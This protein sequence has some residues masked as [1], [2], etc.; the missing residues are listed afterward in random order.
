MTLTSGR[1]YEISQPK[2]KKIRNF[3]NFDSEFYHHTACDVTPSEGYPTTPFPIPKSTRE[4][5][6]DPTRKSTSINL[7]RDFLNNLKNL[8]KVGISLEFFK[9]FWTT[10]TCRNHLSEAPL[11]VTPE[12]TQNQNFGFFFSKK[13]ARILI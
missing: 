3:K 2:T 5:S 8:K 6:K 7:H 13:S 4:R 9:I 11:L 1:P 12:I 10:R